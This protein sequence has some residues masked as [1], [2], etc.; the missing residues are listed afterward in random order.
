MGI[1]SIYHV[2]VGFFFSSKSSKLDQAC[3]SDDVPTG[4]VSLETLTYLLG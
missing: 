1:F 4:P 3:I 2:D